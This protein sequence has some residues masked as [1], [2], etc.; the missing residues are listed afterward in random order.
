MR[1][2]RVKSETNMSSSMPSVVSNDNDEDDGRGASAVD[3][4]RGVQVC[5]HVC[6]CVALSLVR[7]CI[8]E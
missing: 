3:K 8:R 7:V 2:S 1:T 6:A 4:L 5:E